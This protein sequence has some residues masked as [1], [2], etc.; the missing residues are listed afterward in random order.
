MNLFSFF[1]FGNMPNKNVSKF[2]CVFQVMIKSEPSATFQ[3]HYKLFLLDSV[4]SN[5][6]KSIHLLLTQGHGL[7]SVQNHL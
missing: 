4:E 3:W 7:Q 6:I 1:T 2:S 5:Q